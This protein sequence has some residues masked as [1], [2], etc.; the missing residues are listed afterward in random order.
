MTHIRVAAKADRT[1]ADGVLFASRGE[2]RR[3]EELQLLERAGEIQELV[4]QPRWP[5]VLPNGEPV[6]IN[7]ITCHYTG[8]FLYWETTEKLWVC[9]EYKGVMTREAQLR[10]AVFRALHPH[11]HFV[12]SGP[13]KQPHRKRA[14]WKDFA[15]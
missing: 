10:I 12:V 7:G 15:T 11:V 2:M 9:E 13:A 6:Q 1:S 8:D 5:L 4:R 3:W 14:Q